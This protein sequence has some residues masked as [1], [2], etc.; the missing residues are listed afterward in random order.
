MQAWALVAAVMKATRGQ[1]DAARVRAACSS[2]SASP[3]SPRSAGEPCGSTAR[4]APN[5][6]GAHPRTGTGAACSSKTLHRQ[7]APSPVRGSSTG[8]PARQRGARAARRRRRCRRR[9]VDH[10]HGSRSTSTPRR[11]GQVRRLSGPGT[12]ACASAVPSRS[13]RGPPAVDL[14]CTPE[15]R[16]AGSR[17]ARLDRPV[18]STTMPVSLADRGSSPGSPARSSPCRGAGARARRG[19]CRCWATMSMRRD[20]GT[21][22]PARSGR[23]VLLPQLVGDVGAGSR[24]TSPSRPRAGGSGR[25]GAVARSRPRGLR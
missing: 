20:P 22:C 24:G 16:H 21:R 3:S 19:R 1:A 8:T 23:R 18:A 14:G 4:P 13:G 15:L 11:R 5:R 25:Q 7:P 2:A 6:E 12:L 10:Q 17:V 9:R